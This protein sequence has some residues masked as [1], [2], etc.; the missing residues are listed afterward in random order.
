MVSKIEMEIISDSIDSLYD[1]N[2]FNI[3]IESIDI[4]IN[5]IFVWYDN[6]IIGM[7]IINRKIGFK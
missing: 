3:F 1:D 6:I 5:D 4:T 7:M 2:I